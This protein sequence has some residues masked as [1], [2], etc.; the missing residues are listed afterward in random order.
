MQSFMVCVQMHLVCCLKYMYTWQC[1]HRCNTE[2]SAWTFVGHLTDPRPWLDWYGSHILHEHRSCPVACHDSLLKHHNSS[3]LSSVWLSGNQ[4]WHRL[5]F[6]FGNVTA[7]FADKMYRQQW[8]WKRMSYRP[9]IYFS[10]VKQVTVTW[11]S[12]NGQADDD[13][14]N[15][16]YWYSPWT[17]RQACGSDK[18]WCHMLLVRWMHSSQISQGLPNN[19]VYSDLNIKLDLNSLNSF[20]RWSN[21]ATINLQIWRSGNHAINLLRNYSDQDPE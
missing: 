1:L 20:L 7:T 19:Y 16:L 3:L 21:L 13:C 2:Y 6:D 18:C 8:L 12:T 15:E 10:L 17:S 4:N 5:G 11:H 14:T 9:K